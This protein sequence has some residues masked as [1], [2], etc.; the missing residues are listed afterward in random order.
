MTIKFSTQHL[1]LSPTN[2]PAD[3]DVN[4][5]KAIVKNNLGCANIKGTHVKGGLT[6]ACPNIPVE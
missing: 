2:G 1:R 4:P 3:A 5:P 6:P